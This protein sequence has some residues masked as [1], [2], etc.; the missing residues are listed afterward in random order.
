MLQCLRS[1]LI[2][3]SLS[4]YGK[5]CAEFHLYYEMKGLLKPN[6]VYK[7]IQCLEVALLGVVKLAWVWLQEYLYQKLCL[8]DQVCNQICYHTKPSDRV[9]L[10]AKCGPTATRRCNKSFYKISQ[11]G[12]SFT[13]LDPPC[14]GQ[15][16][17]VA[18][19]PALSSSSQVSLYSAVI[20]LSCLSRPAF[21]MS[22][23]SVLTT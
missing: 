11:H 16:A 17:A 2:N 6:L 9:P 3:A 18:V 23:I 20:M 10:M 1:Q 13:L 7:S 5:L 8:V 19:K 22:Q 4:G 14:P 15:S 12:S 21:K